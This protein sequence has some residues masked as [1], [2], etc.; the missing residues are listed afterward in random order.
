MCWYTIKNFSYNIEE[1]IKLLDLLNPNCTNTL[2]RKDVIDFNDLDANIQKEIIEED[3]N[4]YLSGVL[5]IETDELKEKIKNE[6]ISIAGHDLFPGAS[7]FLYCL[8]KAVEVITIE[9]LWKVKK[10]IAKIYS[11][12]G[13]SEESIVFKGIKDLSLRF[14]NNFE[15]EPRY[16]DWY[17]FSVKEK[18]NSKL[19]DTHHYYNIILTNDTNVF[20]NFIFYIEF[21]EDSILN[22]NL[23]FYENRDE[24]IKLI[25]RNF[26][27]QMTKI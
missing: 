10:T 7:D 20:E 17:D 8:N 18:R 9:D 6:I 1:H 13:F 26:N 11:D 15:N 22:L 3:F 19:K 4:N 24:I 25:N 14:I 16:F 23:N 27:C 12:N 5:F 21:Y 2:F